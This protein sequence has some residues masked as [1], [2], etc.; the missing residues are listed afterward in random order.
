MVGVHNAY[1]L[2]QSILAPNVMRLPQSMFIQ[3]HTLA[4]LQPLWP[5]GISDAGITISPKPLSLTA[6]QACYRIIELGGST[7]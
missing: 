4:R 3:R 1:Y 5:P 6:F 2:V 7:A